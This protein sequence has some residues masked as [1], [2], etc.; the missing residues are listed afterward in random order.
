MNAN[1]FLIDPLFGL[2]DHLTAT[3]HYVLSV[4]PGV[5]QAFME[6]V[7]RRSGLKP[8]RYLGAID[9]PFGD[10]TNRP[11]LLI[12]CRDYDVVFEHKVDS[13]LGPRQLHRYLELAKGKGWK[14]ALVA[15]R[16][17][18]VADDVCRS[19]R[20]IWPRSGNG[21][22]HFLWQDIHSIVARS[23][24]HIAREFREYLEALGLGHFSWGNIGDPFIDEYAATELRSI[25]SSLGPVFKGKTCRT[26]TNSLTLEIRRPFRPIHLL[27]VWPVASVAGW[28]KRLWGGAM[29]LSVF[30]KR[31]GDLEERVLAPAYGYLRDC[32]PRVFV[33]DTAP[34]I[35]L[36]QHYDRRIRLELE[37]YVSLDEVLQSS[38]ATSQA[39]LARFVRS[40]SEHLKG[41][42]PLVPQ[43]RPQVDRAEAQLTLP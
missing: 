20:F 27:N 2:E 13:P 1:V 39:R 14:L 9:H 5:G 11:D 19:S 22:T 41:T 4:V 23:N 42:W 17:I 38:K 10:G 6:E 37:Y 30:V 32:S 25:Y 18:N 3:W 29:A 31:E 40:A 15:A 26:R 43:A 8:S 12:R 36:P 24:E 33:T 16:P 28:D 35:G 21:P 34:F 7:A